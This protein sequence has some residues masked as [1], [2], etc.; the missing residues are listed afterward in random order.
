ML[1]VDQ[2]EMDNKNPPENVVQA[3]AECCHSVLD[4]LFIKTE[5]GCI[6]KCANCKRIIVR[7]C[8]CSTDASSR[9]KEVGGLMASLP[10]CTMEMK[11]SEDPKVT[12]TKRR[13]FVPQVHRLFLKR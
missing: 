2:K 13:P 12:K 11:A 3:L 6:V 7:H 4:S 8:P 5:D 1:N 10:C 9:A